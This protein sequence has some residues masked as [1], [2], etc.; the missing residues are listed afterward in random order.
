MNFKG[1]Y[2]L[3]ITFCA[4]CI[5]FFFYGCGFF[6]SD[7][8]IKGQ[9]IDIFSGEP[10]KNITI[11]AVTKT[12][13]EEDKKFERITAKS[14]NNGEFYLKGLSS[15]YIYTIYNQ[16]QGSTTDTLKGIE[17]PEEGKTRILDKPPMSFS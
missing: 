1:K 17:P 10:I 7:S 6:E 15:S 11:I 2:L 13:I 8:S 16:K 3:I 5:S 14:D 12:N 9:V 4:I